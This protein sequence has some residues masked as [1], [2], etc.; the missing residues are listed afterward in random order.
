MLDVSRKRLFELVW[1]RSATEVARELGISDVAL[2]K[3][4]RRLQ[5]PKPPR[6]Y[7]ARKRTG[8]SARRPPLP[9]FRDEYSPEGDR[10]GGARRERKSRQPSGLRLSPR[11]R[12]LFDHAVRHLRGDTPNSDDFTLSGG[13]LTAIDPDF[14]GAVIVALGQH[15]R[16]WGL[17]EG[18]GQRA[19][20][21]LERAVGELLDG[22]LAYA[23]DRV[24]VFKPASHRG[25]PRYAT[26]EDGHALVRFSP[27]L[28][29]EVANLAY[30]TREQELS[31]VA[32]QLGPT[33]H[34]WR[35]RWAWRPDRHILGRTALCVS[36]THVWIRYDEPQQLSGH[37]RVLELESTPLETV[38]PPA[39]IGHKEIDV[40]TVVDRA[41]QRPYAERLRALLRAEE[42]FE[43]AERAWIDVSQGL[44]E[45]HLAKALSLWW[46][47][48]QFAALHE[49]RTGLEEIGSY[50]ETWRDALEQEEYALCRDILGIRYGDAVTGEVRSRR[51]TIRIEHIHLFFIA[52]REELV[53]NLHGARYRKD[54]LPGQRRETV[55]IS[56]HWSNSGDVGAL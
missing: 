42:V 55:P 29:R 28:V 50:L 22:L 52:E 40:P 14:A 1:S 11:K 25:K 51:L 4:S 3:L 27:E 41:H 18:A 2:T 9:S 47:E 10:T 37:D 30:S 7:W 20:Q 54:G 12:E 44:G 13:R 36:A 34:C 21:A 32:R 15:Y 35:A 38:V 53:F 24:V 49:V 19:E 33:D 39:L 23:R 31:F 45:D 43:L 8:K 6:G 5:V 46:T 16:R 17:S 26:Y 48:S 56:V